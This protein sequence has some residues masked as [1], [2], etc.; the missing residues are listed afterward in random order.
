LRDGNQALVKPMTVAQKTRLFTLLV[1]L[2]Y[3]EIEVGF[4]AA[5]QPDFDFVRKLIDEELVPDDVTIQVLTQARKELIERSFEALKGARR[6]VV[7]LYNSTSRVQRNKVFR[8]DVP[9]IKAIAVQGA[10]WVKSMAQE[11]PS[12]EW[13]FQYSPESFTS[14]ELPIAA[15]VVNA[16]VAVWQPEQGQEVIINLPATVEVSMPNVYADMVEW[17][18]DNIHQREHLLVSLHTHNDRGCGV[19]AAEMGV[20]AGADRVEMGRA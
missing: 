16:V 6:A 18:C 2:G 14:T 12:T 15:E 10:E 11:H 4:P 7:H 1:E 5:S 20:L 9:G 8:L 13:V 17:M 3:K 19:A